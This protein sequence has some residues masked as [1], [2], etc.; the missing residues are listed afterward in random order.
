[1]SRIN[2]ILF[3]L[4]K[5][6]FDLRPQD[7]LETLKKDGLNAGIYTFNREIEFVI[8]Q[9]ILP[10]SQSPVDF[11]GT[12]CDLRHKSNGHQCIYRLYVNPNS[13]FTVKRYYDTFKTTLD[14][15]LPCETT[16]DCFYYLL[17][18]ND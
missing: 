11:K 8:H 6:C 7:L 17:N 1:M 15:V 9:S 13:K 10:T 12:I 14:E 18:L 5:E 3:K 4:R 2:K 16:L